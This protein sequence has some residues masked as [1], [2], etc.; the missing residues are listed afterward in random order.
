MD[1]ASFLSDDTFGGSSWADDDVDFSSISIPVQS[2]KTDSGIPGPNFNDPAFGGSE[3]RDHVE[4]PVPD[5]PPYRARINNLPWDANE[6]IVTEWLE[7][8]VGQGATSKLV[9]PR[10]FNDSSR[11]KGFAFVNFEERDQLVK[12]LELSGTEMLGRR[13][14][15]N[16]AAPE[17]EGFGRSRGGFGGDADLDWGAARSGPL[18]PRDD[19]FRG[20]RRPRREDPDLDWGSAR[21]SAAPRSDRPERRP[22][23]EEPNLDWGAARTGPRG[24]PKGFEG[25][26]PRGEPR[27]R[28][29]RREEPALDWGSARGAAAPAPRPE[30]RPKKE[31][32]E[33]DW[34][35]A[36]S[37]SGN[38]N[39]SRSSRNNS[40]S[41]SQ[42]NKYNKKTAAD[43]VDVWTRGGQ[44]T[45]GRRQQQQ[46]AAVVKEEEASSKPAV[47][48]SAF[49]V[50][51]NEDDEDEEEATEKKEDEPKKEAAVTDLKNATS[52]LNVSGGEEGEWEVVG[53][54]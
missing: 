31:E 40:N 15:V 13:V 52:K 23:R 37:T 29:P 9:V 4:Y 51:A 38:T 39:S 35:A 5:A 36:R 47:V 27:E 8:V 45:G 33:L 6:E 28:K 41:Q 12:A 53:K 26:E 18:P 16:V 44:P 14:Y 49:S 1:L 24:E 22:R 20:E 17:K 46:Q 11:V 2:H 30:R 19:D 48:K 34:G 3:R 43:E 21:G 50:L 10:D 54:N 7:G 42:S 25:H 32:P